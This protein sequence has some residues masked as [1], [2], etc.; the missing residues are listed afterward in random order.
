[1]TELTSSRERRRLGREVRG[2]SGSGPFWR[3]RAFEN[4][5]I[6]LVGVIAGCL[7]AVSPLLALGLIGALVA[8][9][10][11]TSAS[12]RLAVVVFGGL[13]VFQSSDGLSGPK[14]GY[15]G[16]YCIAVAV[17][18]L[19]LDRVE[20]RLEQPI[21]PLLLTGPVLLGVIALSAL[22]ALQ[23]GTTVSDWSRDSVAYIF[24]AIS[25]LLALDAAARLRE[26]TILRMF[27]AAG[28]LSAASLALTWVERRGFANLPLDRLFLPSTGLTTALFIYAL[29]RAQI[30][31]QRTGRWIVLAGVVLMFMLVTG[32]RTNLLFLLAPPLLALLAGQGIR[33]VVR[34]SAV[35]VGLLLVAIVLGVVVGRVTG[36]SSDVIS[37]RL[38]SVKSGA[39]S[40][41]VAGQSLQMRVEETQLAWHTFQQHTFT[42]AGLGHRF[43]YKDPFGLISDNY[44]LDTPV[45]LPAKLG[46]VGLLAF[47]LL[48][49]AYWRACRSLRKIADRSVTSALIAFLIIWTLALPLGLAVEEKGFGFA[50]VFLIALSLASID[51]EDAS[52]SAADDGPDVSV[53]LP[54]LRAVGRQTPDRRRTR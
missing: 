6:V 18:F 51:R 4:A 38:A 39:A 23:N 12:T 2:Q 34:L 9:L 43:L 17:A 42:G 7:L 5:G 31:S 32:T 46:L 49:G 29:A 53:E 13:L 26:R 25:P 28:C 21:R 40:G 1:M 11:A 19:N 52:R 16:L 24:L 45:L 3:T 10:V 27:V 44:Y 41:A 20:P 36:V 50:L 48:A 22:V 30:G 15:L 54:T 33:A 47:G 14:V 35:V 8:L 37:S